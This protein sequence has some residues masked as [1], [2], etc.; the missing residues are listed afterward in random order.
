MEGA[1]RI[2]FPHQS[3]RSGLEIPEDSTEELLGELESAPE[4]VQFQTNRLNSPDA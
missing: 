4:K 2:H 3:R 1:E